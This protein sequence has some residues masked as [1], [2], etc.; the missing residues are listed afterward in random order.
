M[1]ISGSRPLPE[2]VTAS[3]GTWATFGCVT[4]AQA[5]GV[6]VAGA[7]AV[8]LAAGAGVT[9]GGGPGGNPSRQRTASAFCST[10]RIS[11]GLVGPRLEAEEAAALYGAGV[12]LA[13]SVAEGRPWKYLSPVQLWP[14]SEEPITWPFCLTRLPLA[15]SWNSAWAA[16]V[17]TS[18]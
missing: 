10:A 5:A 6:A 7:T 16:P 18:G 11:A 15:R 2:A 17:T 1:L 8:A 12:P 9:S 3:T 13:S 14:I 4:A